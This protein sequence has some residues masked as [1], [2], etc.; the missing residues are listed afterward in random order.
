MWGGV[1]VAGEEGGRLGAVDMSKQLAINSKTYPHFPRLTHDS[2]M[3]CMHIKKG[4]G[5]KTQRLFFLSKYMLRYYLSCTS[6]TP[7]VPE[8]AAHIHQQRREA[9]VD[10]SNDIYH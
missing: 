9:W 8:N 4:E 6:P 7:S 10:I 1:G 2:L 5:N 3:A